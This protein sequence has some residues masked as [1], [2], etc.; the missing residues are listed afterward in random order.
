MVWRFE[1]TADNADD[2]GVLSHLFS[3][4]DPRVERT[5]EHGELVTELIDPDAAPSTAIEEA[6]V[7]LDRMNGFAGTVDLQQG[8]CEL[9]GRHT[10][11]SGEPGAVARPG[12]VAVST[13]VLPSAAAADGQSAPALPGPAV[14]RR[15]D[16]D[17]AVAD[18]LYL[19]AN[20]PRDWFTLYK[21]YEII[22]HEIGKRGITARG[23][24]TKKQLKRFVASANHPGLSKHDARHA[25]AKG[26][27]PS[28]SLLMA[29]DEAAQLAITMA[30]EFL[31][32]RSQHPS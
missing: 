11:P 15:A 3:D 7:L 9:T 8:C 13:R 17:P 25:R 19:M 29:L 6:A 23:W 22:E 28:P 16:E 26:S 27:P 4:D 30:H 21:L 5:A 18:L 14:I 20:H 10:E 24:A 31:I 32:E 1:V 12:A 2:L